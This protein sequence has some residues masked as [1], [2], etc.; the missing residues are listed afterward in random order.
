MPATVFP[1]WVEGQMPVVRQED[2]GLF[3]LYP[4]SKPRPHFL[5]RTAM[6]V[7]ECCD[8]EHSLDDLARVL[9]ARFADA[10]RDTLARDVQRCL[11]LFQTLGLVDW[12]ERAPENPADG[13]RP[14]DEGDF[15]PISEF[16]TRRA[17]EPPAPGGFDFTYVAADGDLGQIYRD[18]ALRTRQFH[19]L[20]IFFVLRQHGRV[21]AVA[22]VR[23]SSSLG[24]VMLFTVLLAERGPDE[25]ELD[26]QLIRGVT[27]H[28]AKL[29]MVR[30]RFS[31]RAETTS[32]AQRRFLEAAG[33]AFEARLLDEYGAGKHVDLWSRSTAG[34][35]GTAE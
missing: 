32:D 16:I 24:Q 34:G 9:A 23:P 29:G 33:F 35:T 31:L 2:E 25:E 18:I 28:L 13:V 4:P 10:P 5:N 8:G 30:I 11:H 15:G 19:F 3:L 20:E 7:L 21:Q 17:I 26:R 22:A 6:A 27:E 1:R 14:A 12:P